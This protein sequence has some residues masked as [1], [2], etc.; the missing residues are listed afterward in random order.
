MKIT[1]PDLLQL[2][3]VDRI[4]PEPAGG[5]HA[6]PEWR[7]RRSWWWLLRAWWRARG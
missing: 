5:A 6:E 3:I 7:V 4:V 1:A 2:G